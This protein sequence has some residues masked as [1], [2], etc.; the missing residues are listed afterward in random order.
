[1]NISVSK[2]V[3]NNNNN[4]QDTNMDSQ[5]ETQAQ[6]QTPSLG[7]LMTGVTL[8]F[9]SHV[10]A[11]AQRLVELTDGKVSENEIFSAWNSV[12]DIQLVL[13]KPSTPPA[14]KTRAS[15]KSAKPAEKSTKPTDTPETPDSTT[16]SA[17]RKPIITGVRCAYMFKRGARK[18]QECGANVPDEGRTT[19]NRHKKYEEISGTTPIEDV[20]ELKKDQPKP[21][22]K[23][24]KMPSSRKLF[25]D[26]VTGRYIHPSTGLVIDKDSK[27]VVG[28]QNEEGDIIPLTLED[29]NNAAKFNFKVSDTARV[30]NNEDN[31]DDEDDEDNKDDEDNEEKEHVVQ[32]DK[33]E[34]VEYNDEEKSPTNNDDDEDEDEDELVE[35]EED[36]ELED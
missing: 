16:S 5:Q 13:A 20:S 35:E 14:K 1:M 32:E 8:V 26:K 12:S 33:E 6:A 11:F 7:S 34:L 28:T 21:V 4:D 24:V 29:I 36:D 3:N 10:T 25:K 31:K 19:C 9:Q 30:E 27:K 2:V 15:A 18:E 17:P 22:K 23:Q